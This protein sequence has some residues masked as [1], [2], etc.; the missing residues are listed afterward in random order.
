MARPRIPDEDKIR[1]ASDIGLA[2]ED[3]DR[4]AYLAERWGI[5]KSAAARRAIREAWEREG[6]RKSKLERPRWA[7]GAP[8]RDGLWWCKVSEPVIGGDHQLRVRLCRF[9]AS[10]YPRLTHAEGSGSCDVL[11]VSSHWSEP[12]EPPPR[13]R[14][15][16]V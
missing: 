2:R 7:R 11:A 10:D 14:K 4:L 9:R 3:R 12:V 5:G 15:C 16:P 13:S 6:G 8:K 1:P